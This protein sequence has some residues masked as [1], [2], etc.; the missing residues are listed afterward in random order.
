MKYFVALPMVASV[1]AAQM[2]VMALASA[3]PA[4]AAT[5]V[6]SKADG[7]TI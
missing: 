6:V 1:A 5:H 2:N 3:P 4:G 7:A